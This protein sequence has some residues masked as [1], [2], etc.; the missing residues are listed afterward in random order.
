MDPATHTHT[1]QCPYYLLVWTGDEKNAKN[2][3]LDVEEDRIL[4]YIC[5]YFDI[6]MLKSFAFLYIHARHYNYSV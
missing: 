2:I 5:R 3:I 1:Q 6:L 4:D